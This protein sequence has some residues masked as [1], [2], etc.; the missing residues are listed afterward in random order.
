M[1]YATF[2]D[3]EPI[4]KLDDDGNKIIADTIDGVD[5]YV[6]IGRTEPHY[7][8]PIPFEGTIRT[9]GNNVDYT[10]YGINKGDYDAIL[11]LMGKSLPIAENTLIW[12]DIE[13]TEVVEDTATYRVVRK[14]EAINTTRFVLERVVNN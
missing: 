10:E 7:T 1:W 5:Y 11:V 6:E 3:S 14:V 9:G 12:C 2:V 4:Y 13:P 8:D